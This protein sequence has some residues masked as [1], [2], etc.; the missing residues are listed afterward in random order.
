FLLPLVSPRSAS[1]FDFLADPIFLADEP[2]QLENTLAELYEGLAERFS[3]SIDGG[4]IALSP[5][6]LFLDAEKLRMELD[7]FKRIELRALGRDAA[8]TDEAIAVE[9]SLEANTPLFL[10]P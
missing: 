10:F 6:E 4:V 7:R 9:S 5:D 1:I 2:L 3:R 8:A